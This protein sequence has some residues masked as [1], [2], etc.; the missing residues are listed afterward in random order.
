MPF[1]VPSTDNIPRDGNSFQAIARNAFASVTRR[2]G[3]VTMAAAMVHRQDVPASATDL[4]RP[5]P[6]RPSN[7]NILK[8]VI[9]GLVAAAVGVGIWIAIGYY[10]NAEVGYVAWGIGFLAGL[11][12]RL[13]AGAENEG[14]FPGVLGVGIAVVAILGAKYAVTSLLV[15]K[16][17]AEALAE[18]ATITFSEDDNV[19]VLAQTMVEEQTAAG[20]KFPEPTEA[21]LENDVRSDDFPPA[22]WA[23]AKKQWGA[24]SKDEQAT[25]AAATK[26]SFEEATKQFAGMMRGKVFEEA[27]R[28]SFGMYDLLWFG[29]AAF[30][31]FKV[32]SGTAGSDH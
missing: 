30:T 17:M 2:S 26:A 16:H 4:F 12:V 14:V 18:T 22:I 7:M 1:N 3:V 10:A 8:Q 20:K 28:E 24:L 19:G 31:A 15:D 5:Q 9:A 32:G 29:L 27:F 6:E 11:G 25:R 23:A 21:A 13:A